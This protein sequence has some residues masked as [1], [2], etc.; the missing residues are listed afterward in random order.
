MAK[1]G[2]I[3]GTTSSAYCISKIE[4]TSTPDPNVANNKSTVTAKL[5]LRRTNEYT[6]YGSGWSIVISIGGKTTTITP[7]YKEVT[8]SWVLMGTATATIPHNDDGSK[9]ITIYATGGCPGTSVTSI[10]CSDTVALDTIPRASSITCTPAD[11]ESKPT[12]TITRASPGFTHTIAYQYGTLT[13]TIISKT[14]ATSITSWTIPTSFYA[15]TPKKTG[16]GTLICTTYS[17]NTPIGTDTCDLNVTTN[18]AKCK[19]TVTVSAVDKNE[20]TIALTGSNKTIIKGYS[21]V[22]VTTIAEEKN[23]AK[24]SSLT[25]ACGEEKKTGE[26]VTFNDAQSATITA[27]AIDSREYSNKATVSGLKLV[28]YIDPTIVEAISRESPT[29]NTVNIS[30]TGHWFNG[31]FGV[32]ANTIKV[33]VRYKPKSQSSY[34]DTDKYTDMAVTFDGNT[35]KAS[36]SLDGLLYTQA[37]SI[38]IRVTDAIH[39]YEGPIAEA[40]YRNTE[41]SKGIPVFDWG[42]NDFRFNVPVFVGDNSYAPGAFEPGVKMWFGSVRIA[43]TEAN[44]ITSEEI[45]LPYGYFTETPCA[46]VTPSSTVPDKVRCSCMPTK[47][48]ITVYMVRDNTTETAIYVLAIGK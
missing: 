48:K 46:F 44:A 34:E 17:G 31:N 18:E 38:R 9:S 11:I 20:N 32:S 43:P 2:T 19:P 45:T 12:I 5:Y 6:T 24:I 16:K 28:N 1:S 35:Y 40:V 25:V 3:N 29:S 7:G 33:Q 14:A 15:Q 27:T 39:E 30:V 22:E 8:S 42:E 4:W 47:D 10:S 26:K 21:D 13:G 37:Y 41:I 36:V 23:S